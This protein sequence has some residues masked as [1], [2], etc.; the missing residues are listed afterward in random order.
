[1]VYAKSSS[2]TTKRAHLEKKHAPEY[3]AEIQRRGWENKMP[4]ASLE[5]L[6]QS[7]ML[8]A[9]RI[10]FSTKDL[11]KMIVKLI[12]AQ[13]LVCFI[14]LVCLNYKFIIYVYSHLISLKAGSSVIYFSFYVKHSMIKIFPT[15]PS[16]ALSSLKSGLST[17]MT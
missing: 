14:I 16:S 8:A 7:R 1:V 4:S 6:K 2:L 12:V 17:G 5:N 15:E 13:D 11:A 3:L 9:Q 10:P